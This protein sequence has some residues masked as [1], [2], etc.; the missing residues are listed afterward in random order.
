MVETNRFAANYADFAANA[1][2]YGLSGL[3]SAGC[4]RFR[5]CSQW[6]SGRIY[7]IQ[8]RGGSYGFLQI[9]HRWLHIDFGAT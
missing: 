7:R 3:L 2:P 9:L 6:I 1:Q 4:D 5:A 8:W